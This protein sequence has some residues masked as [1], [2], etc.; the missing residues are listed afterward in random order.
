MATYQSGKRLRASEQDADRKNA[1]MGKPDGKPLWWD[2][3]SHDG[4]R[5]PECKHTHERKKATGLHCG[6]SMHLDSRGG[7]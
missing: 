6:V 4:R 3:N 5:D 7:L 2:Y 1:T